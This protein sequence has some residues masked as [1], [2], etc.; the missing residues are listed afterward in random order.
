MRGEKS[1]TDLRLIA[2]VLRTHL[3]ANAWPPGIFLERLKCSPA[4]KRSARG[5]A[6]ANQTTKTLFELTPKRA[7][8]SRLCC[9]EPP[10]SSPLP[11]RERSP[12]LVRAG[13]GLGCL[14]KGART[15]EHPHHPH[16]ASLR[17]ATFSR[18]AGEGTL[19]TQKRRRLATAAFKFAGLDPYIAL[20]RIMRRSSSGSPDW[21]RLRAW[22]G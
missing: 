11:V 7:P 13:E 5:R 16:P 15:S 10:P 2:K 22:L 12:E 9:G 4:G 19:L 18:P 6:S 21:R 3:S 1:R 8:L 20:K 14:K 17:S